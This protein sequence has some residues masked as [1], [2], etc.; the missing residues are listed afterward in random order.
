[1]AAGIVRASLALR[2]PP[3]AR[4]RRLWLDATRDAARDNEYDIQYSLPWPAQRSDDKRR[5]ILQAA[6]KVFARKGYFAARVSEIAQRA[7]VADGTI[8]LYFRAR[9]TSSSPSSTS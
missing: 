3:R 9:R 5:R 2:S 4:T 6:V 7:G 8:Y 1:M